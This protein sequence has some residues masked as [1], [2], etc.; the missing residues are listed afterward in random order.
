MLSSVSTEAKVARKTE[1]LPTE[2]IVVA[3]QEP[4]VPASATK[5]DAK[6]V[7]KAAKQ[8]RDILARTVSQ[9]LEEVGNYLLDTFYEGK[10]ELYQ[11]MKPSKHASLTLLEDRCETLELPVSR[12]FLANAIGVAV[13]TKHLPKSSS[14]L[15]L[16]PSHKTEL[17]G[18]STPEKAENL[19]AKV[20]EGKLTV[21]KLRELVRKERAKGKKNPQGRKPTPTVVRVLT[22]CAKLLRDQATGRLVFRKAD[23]AELTPEQVE[24]VQELR[25]TIV[26]RM[27]EIAKAI[28]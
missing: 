17:L 25:E 1:V 10:P 7:D 13:M 6:L 24:E 22:A 16:P 19:A 20:L 27:D 21:Q 11:S 14:F 3:D 2:A 23:F 9:G 12:T 15:K 4:A 28:G 26:K 5:P 18:I 8:I